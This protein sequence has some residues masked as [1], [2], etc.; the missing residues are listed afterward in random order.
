MFSMHNF[1]AHVIDNEP[2][3][4]RTFK[5]LELLCVYMKLGINMNWILVLKKY[6]EQ[7]LPHPS[8]L[9]PNFLYWFLAYMNLSFDV[10]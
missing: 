3:V 1:I 4:K 7:R 10:K 9:F 6:I 5:N 8:S 2:C